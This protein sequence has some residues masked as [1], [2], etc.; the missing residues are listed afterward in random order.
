MLLKVIISSDS[1]RLPVAWES[2][3]ETA[4]LQVEVFKSYMTADTYQQAHD[5]LW[6]LEQNTSLQKDYLRKCIRESVGFEEVMLEVGAAIESLLSL[7]DE[8]IMKLIARL[9]ASR[10]VQHRIGINAAEC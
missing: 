6:K 4:I 3:K 10:T 7:Q 1:K 2:L 9:Q 8:F 5:H